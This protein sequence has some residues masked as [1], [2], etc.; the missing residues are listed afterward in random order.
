MLTDNEIR[1][2]QVYKEQKDIRRKGHLK[3]K[4]PSRK[5]THLLHYLLRVKQLQ[6]L[7]VPKVW[8]YLI[9]ICG[10]SKYTFRL[11]IQY[12]NCIPKV[13]GIKEF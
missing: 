10:M 2:I 5:T 3:S 9:N 1:I 6:A 4:C 12:F 7:K 11:R 8:K 13:S